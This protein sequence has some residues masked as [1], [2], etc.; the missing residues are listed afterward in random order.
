MDAMRSAGLDPNLTLDGQVEMISALSDQFERN[1]TTEMAAAEFGMSVEEFYKRLPRAGKIG[2][3]LSRR[4]KQDQVPRDQFIGQFT[5]ILEDMTSNTSIAQLESDDATDKVKKER[6]DRDTFDLA[7]FANKQEYDVDEKAVFT[8]KSDK[9][10]FLTVINVDSIGTSTVLLPNKFRNDPVKL[11]AGE[12]LIFPGERDDFHF[13]L[14]DPGK[15]K[16]IA[17]CSTSHDYIP[18]S[19]YDFKTATFAEQGTEKK[20]NR[21]LG[22]AAKTYTREIMVEGKKIKKIALET[23]DRKENAK[24]VAHARKSITIVVH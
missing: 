19:K 4:L 18:G 16:V 7:L 2:F 13:R 5:Q 12:E 3:D 23:K 14:A 20:L 10:C 6:D 11:K 17:L 24:L 15:E 9:A 22:N 8:I 1:L 21:S